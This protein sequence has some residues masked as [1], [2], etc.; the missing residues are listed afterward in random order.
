MRIEARKPLQALGLAFALAALPGAA[1][2]QDEVELKGPDWVSHQGARLVIGQDSF[3][4]QNPRPSRE[5]LGSA[6]GVAF[7]GN[8]L[9]V[10]DGNRIGAFPVNNR[11]LIYNDVSGFV[12]PPEELL[13]QDRACPACVGLPDVVLG[14][15]DFDTTDSSD[16]PDTPGLNNPS[17][18]H[19]DG[20]RLAVAD[21]NN[22]RVL[23][24]SAL[25]TVNG[26]EP[27]LVLGQPDF[28]TNFPATSPTGMRGP[29]GVWLDG[30]R[31]FV[32]DTQN[33]RV[34][35]WNQW[36]ASNGQMP[37]V[38]VG[39][40]DLNT[41][42]EADLTQGVYD[43][44]ERRL[45]DPVAVTV[46]G[47][48]MF[49]ADLGFN[50]VL[51]YNAVP[52]QNYPAADVVVGQPDFVSGLRNNVEAM[53]DPIGPLDDDGSRSENETPP[54]N[55]PLAVPLPPLREEIDPDVARYPRRCEGT[56]NFPR[57]ALPIDGRLFIADAG[58]DRVLIYNSIPETNGARADL[59][60]G[61][62]NFVQL[63]ESEGPGSVRSPTAMA[64][65]GQ[66]LYVADPF[67]RRILVFTPGMDQIELDGV[68]NAAAVSIHSRG[69]LDFDQELPVDI[70]DTEEDESRLPPVLPG[71]DELRITLDGI[72]L[73]YTTQEGDTTETVR[74]KVIELINANDDLPVT[75]H[76]SLG[77]GRHATGTIRFGGEAR[78]GDLVTLAINGR[79]YSYTVPEGDVPERFVDRLNFL[80]DNADDPEVIAERKIDEIETLELV[81]RNV[82]PVGNSLPFSIS[83]TPGSP[84]TAE[85][86]GPTLSR[87]KV[88]Y[89][90]NMVAKREGP[91]GN[92]TTVELRNTGA[93]L[94]AETSGSRLT[95]GSDAR[96]LPP[97]TIASIFGT[98]L[99]EGLSSMPDGVELPGVELPTEID[100]VQVLAN[101]R[102][103][104]LLMV[105]EN[106]IN[107]Q[108]P[109]EL[110]GTGFSFQV[111][112]AMPDGSVRVSAAR[113]NQSVRAAPGLFAHA[114]EEPRLAMAVHATGIAEGSIAVT[115]P[116]RPRDN[117]PDNDATEN[118]RL[119]R[120]GAEG[121]IVVNGR[122]YSYRSP[123]DESEE[124]IRD[125]FI[126]LINAGDG[127]PDVI[128]SASTRGFFSARA[129][130]DFG[131]EPAAGDTVTIT[132]R[133]R[134]YS[135]TLTGDDVL[136]SGQALR[137]MRNILVRSVNSG[138]GD[139]E[140][141]ARTLQVVGAT[142]MQIV[143]RSLGSDGNEIPFSF[144]VS[145]GAGIE[146]TTNRE[147]GFL[148]DGNSP[149]VVLLKAR[150][151][152]KQGNDITYAAKGTEV[153]D[154]DP[155]TPDVNERAEAD[156]MLTL[157]ARG[158]H[159]CCGNEA[160][161]PITPENP[162]VPGETI[163]VFATG[164]GLTDNQN[165]IATG[166]PTPE[167]AV[168]NVP[169]VAEDFVSSQFGG[170]TAQVEF[171]GLM[172]GSVGVY[173]VNLRTNT[174]LNDNPATPLWIA[175]GLFISNV[176][177]LPVKNLV[178]RPP[179]DF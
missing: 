110:E 59:V 142:R 14:Q 38:V 134:S 1:S 148:E 99:A 111:R 124:Q 129:D 80:V 67:T 160:F 128:A 21:T 92:W 163:I 177:T 7:A 91:T 140:V 167:G 103:A 175:Q 69:H 164:L 51:I 155:A 46:S 4:R 150:E 141:T 58:N 29:Q 168:A 62:P 137:I 24:W 108:V 154:D 113:A 166:Q 5:V 115:V 153:P 162:L 131:G 30:G 151:P 16:L 48:R 64:Y 152:G 169:L 54:T 40:S 34:L 50:R 95:G 53:C 73:F 143:A 83:L 36:P 45:L 116:E 96:D 81:H 35:V 8:R 174:D 23:L 74:D 13:P 61:Q 25:P 132:V 158:S 107:F 106:Q 2:A 82:G 120:E 68:R 133:D 114:G 165:A 44:D 122:E 9:F 118:R 157:S 78:A 144:E 10:A 57:F 49:V 178:P 17:A 65:D 79:E 33:S 71:G 146:V 12:P 31:L 149:P 43:P 172:E 139:P 156:V 70:S 97:G 19:S 60:I 28:V 101:G 136:D 112:R 127:D 56:L 159:L 105:S 123:G 84:T 55:V 135:Y 161:S 15:P 171:V 102:L 52:T 109:W 126:E 32:A 179:L 119:T 47:G 77:V 26:T 66:N 87:G 145:Q 41:R 90:A 42:H 170:R 37:D 89:R 22:N 86:S 176:V 39:Q 121:R 27:D 11:I 138:V 6:Q 117:D 63:T 147:N 98:Q 104:P 18:V 72:E 75:A 173:Q 88:S 93:D 76:P 85:V 20:V 130:F 100:G 3:T 94:D 125:Q